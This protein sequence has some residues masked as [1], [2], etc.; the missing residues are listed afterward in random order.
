MGDLDV[1]L[2]IGSKVGFRRSSTTTFV[3]HIGQTIV[4]GI[5]SVIPFTTTTLSLDGVIGSDVVFTGIRILQVS[6]TT[7]FTMAP[8]K[9]SQ[10]QT[11]YITN[12]GSTSLSVLNYSFTEDGASLNI[13]SYSP[14][15]LVIP[16]G[17]TGTVTISYTGGQVLGEYSN[18]LVIVTN[19]SNPGYKVKTRQI[20]TDQFLLQIQAQPQGTSTTITRFGQSFDTVYRMSATFDDIPIDSNL[21]S[22]TA[23][24]PQGS[25]WKV[26]PQ[27]LLSNEISVRYTV[28]YGTTSTVTTTSINISGQYQNNSYYYHSITTQNTATVNINTALY[29]NLGGWISALTLPDAIVGISIDY[30]PIDNQPVRHLTIGVGSAVNLGPGLDNLGQSFTNIQ[31]LRP[32]ANQ[33]DYPFAFWQTVCQIPMV[34]TTT[35]TTYFSGDYR[36]KS[37]EPL[38]R[39]YEWYFGHYDSEG[40]MFIVE[41]DP[42]GQIFIRFNDLR[43]Y[44]TS[45]TINQT[46]DRIQRSFYL[47]SPTDSAYRVNGQIETQARD[48]FG[49]YAASGL[50]T[51]LFIGFDNDNLPL[52]SL[53]RFPS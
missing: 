51:H 52:F 16:G 5:N 17:Q 9:R 24:A 4:G 38:F 7:V 19:A 31:W 33:G 18:N 26:L 46:L 27:G 32:E 25:G 41:Q 3:N 43:E 34:S 8:G 47:F 2:T 48:E 21:V 40:S 36:V 39:D 49:Q 20:V 29:G 44:S 22:F 10:L 12:A 6:T 35:L 28:P 13:E 53:V 1:N 37:Q 15:N 42:V 30:M 45:T 50:N 23:T 11:I 14:P